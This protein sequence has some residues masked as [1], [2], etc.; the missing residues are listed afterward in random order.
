[1]KLKWLLLEKK[2]DVTKNQMKLWFNECMRKFFNKHYDKIGNEWPMPV[3]EV[4]SNKTRAG[5]YMCSFKGDAVVNPVIGLN[6]DFLDHAAKNII[7]HE[8]IHYVQSNEYSYYQFSQ[9]SNK[10]H[11]T[12]FTEYMNKIN[13]VEGADFVTVKQDTANLDVVSGGKEFWV[14]GIKTH[15]N[16]FGFAYSATERPNVVEHLKKQKSINKYKQIYA[17]K[18][19]KFKYKIGSI[20]KTG[21]KFGVPNEQENI[22]TEISKYEIS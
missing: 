9:A 4:K 1:M 10:G 20:T 6:P 17:F 14:Y 21:I 16:E 2:H 7:F 22:E 11:D 12:F 5:W 18:S 13:A 15:K 3:F 19:N 8:T